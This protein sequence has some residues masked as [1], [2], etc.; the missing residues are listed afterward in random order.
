MYHD[1]LTPPAGGRRGCSIP[2]MFLVCAPIMATKMAWAAQWAGIGPLLESLLSSWQVQLIQFIGPVTGILIAPAVGAH[3]DRNTSRYGQ[4]RPYM[5]FGA[6]ATIVCWL[7]MSMI[8]SIVA[9]GH[10]A[11]EHEQTLVAAATIFCYLWMDIAVNAVQVASY[12]L[13]S[14]VAGDRQ[15]IASSIATMYSILG[16][17]CVSVFIWTQ[18]PATGYIKWFFTML[19]VF[20]LCT[21]GPVCRFVQETPREKYELPP[22]THHVL[23]SCVYG[24]KTLPKQLLVFF[25]AFVLTEYG[26]ISYTGVKGQ[27]F[28][29]QVYDGTK[30]GA[31]KCGTNCT[32]AQRRY[33]DGVALAGGLTDNLFN[34]LGLLFVGCLPYLV[35]R[36]G[37]R[38]VLLYTLLPQLGLVLLALIHVVWVDV[39]LVVATTL[40][41]QTIYSLIIPLVVSVLGTTDDKSRLGLYFGAIN[42]AVCLGQLLN[43]AVTALVLSDNGTDF[44]VPILVGGVVSGAAMVVIYKL[45][46]VRLQS[47]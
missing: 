27:F 39:V 17:L 12:L 4:R 6:L 29:L 34:V 3:S 38:N 8:P 35:K 40:T 25:A 33:N 1:S 44:S 43:F 46:R 23:L 31:D 15:V 26:F 21:V 30:A 10:H 5:F 7:L 22:P 36:F 24:V 32:S 14:D 16:Q 28:G 18:G 37:A 2:F 9:A 42:T 13:I 47:W 45:F 20:M 41:Q 11:S 19:V